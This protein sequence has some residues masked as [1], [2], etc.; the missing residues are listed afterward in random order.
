MT[1]IFKILL[2]LEG[3]YPAVIITQQNK[4]SHVY[5]LQKCLSIVVIP[6][7]F[8]FL[9]VTGV[10]FFDKDQQIGPGGPIVNHSLNFNLFLLRL[11]IVIL[12]LHA[13]FKI[14][15]S[16]KFLHN[17][18][19]HCRLLEIL[20]LPEESSRY[21]WKSLL[22]FGITSFVELI[23]F[24]V[25][26][27]TD[28]IPD[29]SPKY[30]QFANRV[31]TKLSEAFEFVFTTIFFNPHVVDSLLFGVMCYMQLFARM[32]Q[33][34]NC[35][36]KKHAESL[37]NLGQRRPAWD[38]DVPLKPASDF[39]EEE[40]LVYQ[41]NSTKR[42]QTKSGIDFD[43]KETNNA[44][45]LEPNTLP[46]ICSELVDLWEETKSITSFICLFAF[47]LWTFV[48]G[49]N[50]FHIIS[51]TSQAGVFNPMVYNFYLSGLFLAVKLISSTNC[52]QAVQDEVSHFV[53][54]DFP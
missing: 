35:H 52:A 13:L 4:R 39:L 40:F 10:H 45:L 24:L 21:L 8:Y 38:L 44:L 26:Y 50:T 41:V 20:K 11:I 15:L 9:I 30:I 28:T 23:L 25:T 42:V 37:R 32:L 34:V 31:L 1:K 22:F 17:F 49:V 27:Y 19:R 46:I 12:R 48:L 33:Q 51:A 5:Q 6:I 29:P 36:L 43:N 7:C 18:K 3:L 54:P 16:P 2:F 14:S 53:F 47:S